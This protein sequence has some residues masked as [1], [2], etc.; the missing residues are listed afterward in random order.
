MVRIGNKIKNT[1]YKKRKCAYIII[2][3]EE[4]NKIAIA[5][6]GLFFLLGGGL[7][8]DENEIQALK[9]ELLEETG[10][11]I[12]NIIFFDKV[13]SWILDPKRGYLDITAT[14]YIGKF[15]KKVI[16]PIEL[17]HKILWVNPCDY[18]NKLYHDY[19]KYILNKYIQMKGIKDND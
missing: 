14:I 7:E 11:E 17:D 9:R 12:K 3:R 6:D 1:T 10:Y 2:E 4:D 13:T 19:Q 16:E 8:N 15:D 5:T 18:K